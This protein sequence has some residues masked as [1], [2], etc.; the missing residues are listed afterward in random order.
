MFWSKVF[1]TEREILAAICDEEL[2]GKTLTHGKISVKIS[3]DFYGGSL[4]DETE[5]KEMMKK[6]TSGNLFGK[7]IVNLAEKAGFIMKKSV[8][9]I[10]GIPHAQFVRI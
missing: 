7:N 1:K 10:D 4:V 8:I 3:K 2:L 6:A 5:A 9:F